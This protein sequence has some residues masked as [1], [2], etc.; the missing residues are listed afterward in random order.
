MKYFERYFIY[1][2]LGLF[3]P[4]VIDNCFDVDT[5]QYWAAIITTGI[6]MITH[7]VIRDLRYF[8]HEEWLKK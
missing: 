4:F 2:I 5:W 7:M 1:A 3:T 6:I 8:K